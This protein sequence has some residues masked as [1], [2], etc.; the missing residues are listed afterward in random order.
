MRTLL[1]VATGQ[2]VAYRFKRTRAEF[3]EE[4]VGQYFDVDSIP[5][6]VA[7]KSTLLD[8]CERRNGQGND[9]YQAICFAAHGDPGIVYDKDDNALFSNDFDDQELSK[10]VEQRT[11]YLF[12]CKTAED[13]F[14]E[15][16][17]SL[18]CALFIGFSQSPAWLTTDGAR[19][20]SDIDVS[21]MRSIGFDLGKTGVEDTVQDFLSTI[22]SS[23]GRYSD[24]Y[25]LDLNSIEQALQT[26]VV[27]SA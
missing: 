27:V 7:T 16:L 17:M 14:V 13:G 25:D 6:V 3:I 11:I 24:M 18:G 9:L 1:N 22:A 21:V 15:R 10:V 2:D 26:M 19:L 12:A 20:W 4:S 8:Y 23:R 5:S